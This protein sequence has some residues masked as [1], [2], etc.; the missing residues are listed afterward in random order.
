MR[1]TLEIK[2]ILF[3]LHAPK[4]EHRSI[5]QSPNVEA[6]VKPASPI[7]DYARA[8][9]QCAQV[10]EGTPKDDRVFMRLAGQAKHDL[11]FTTAGTTSIK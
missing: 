1:P 6:F 2:F 4:F 5:I 11:G 9:D 3:I 10:R 8:L 7:I